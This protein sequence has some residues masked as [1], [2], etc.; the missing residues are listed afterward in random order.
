MAKFIRREDIGGGRSRGV[1]VC[2]CGAEVLC[3][4]FTNTC[5]CGCDYNMSGQQ[6]ASRSQ[7]GEETGEHPAEIARL[8]GY[9]EF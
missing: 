6:L 1:V 3:Y 4:G 5:D 2:G 7:W 8:T 9:E